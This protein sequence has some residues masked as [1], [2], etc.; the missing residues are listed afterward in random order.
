[1]S[2]DAAKPRIMIGRSGFRGA[3]ISSGLVVVDPRA[4]AIRHSDPKTVLVDCR[5]LADPQKE[6]KGVLKLSEIKASLL[7]DQEHKTLE[8]ANK[9]VDAVL[10]G[11]NACV[12]CMMGRHRSQS[13]ASIAIEILEG[14]HPGVSFEGPVYLGNIKKTE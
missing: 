11:K 3:K 12:M 7:R 1:M 6:C 5:A 2:D 13:V 8:L 10:D 9:V 4:K 14:S